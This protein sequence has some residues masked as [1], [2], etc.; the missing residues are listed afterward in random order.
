MSAVLTVFIPI[1]LPESFSVY[2]Q[3]GNSISG[4]IFGLNRQ[5]LEN[6][7]VELLDDLN[8]SVIRRRTNASGYYSFNR[9]PSGRSSVRVMPFGTDYE[10]ETKGVEI[11][12]I[13]RSSSPNGGSTTG[14]FENVQ[15]DFFLKLRKGLTGAT[16]AIFVQQVP[17]GAKKLYEKAVADL[18]DKKEKEGLQGLRSALEIFPDYYLALER[19][20]SEYVKRGA[21]GTQY[22]EAARLLLSKAVE[23][24]PRGFYSWY[25][26]AYSLNSLNKYDEASK[27]IKKAIEIYPNWSEALLLSG[28]LLRQN[29]EFEE[30]EKQLLKA[31]ENARATVPEIHWQLALLYGNDLK[32]YRDA[33]KELKLFLKALPDAKNAEQIKKLIADFEAKAEKN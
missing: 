15:L 32:R 19:L 22:F 24:N 26:L 27:A 21:S 10:E 20:G 29:K 31:K 33:A 6:V 23:I 14:G 3:V 17:D 1:F 2:G 13:T 30:A 25:G 7:E 9:V 5:P 16:G 12:N 8:R 18:D 4:Y 28:V 11:V